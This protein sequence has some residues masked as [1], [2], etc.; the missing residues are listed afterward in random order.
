MSLVVACR[1]GWFFCQLTPS[2]CP[3][4]SHS[5]IRSQEPPPPSLPPSSHHI[6]TPHHR[7]AD[8][9]ARLATSFYWP[10]HKTSGVGKHLSSAL[11]E[12][13]CANHTGSLSSIDDPWV[14]S[15]YTTE[16]G[17]I[18]CIKYLLYSYNCFFSAIWES[19]VPAYVTPFCILYTEN[20]LIVIGGIAD[21]ISKA[22]L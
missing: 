8:T 21:L 2:P 5:L 6:K 17:R 16:E 19:S 20:V 22:I 4:G 18:D 10:V 3:S 11:L 13:A 12:A 15:V 9:E 14:Q 1:A 7:P